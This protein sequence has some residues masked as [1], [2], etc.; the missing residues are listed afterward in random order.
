MYG[1]VVA[2]KT[3][4]D[5][6]IINKMDNLL[7]ELHGLDS[8]DLKDIARKF[9]ISLTPSGKTALIQR[10]YNRYCDIKKYISYT[11][12]KQLGHEGKDGRTF[13]ALDEHNHEVAIKI[14][15]K[16]KNSHSIEREAKLQSIAAE[17]GIAPKVL[18][19]DGE[20][21]FIVMEKLDVNLFDC[22][23]KQ[24]GQLTRSQQKW[25]IKLFKK[26]DECKVFHGDPNPLNF[27]KKGNKW[28]I[29][30]FGF[31][32]LMN[33][34]NRLRYGDTPNMTYMPLGLKMKLRKVYEHCELEIIERYC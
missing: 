5:K 1:S 12:V 7:I 17:K 23:K 28:F 27:M 26:L 3:L 16:H 6:G 18:H 20:G 32:K 25:I 21:K 22:F 33:R 34:T 9:N 19:Y 11:Y 30:D 2:E 14:F 13:L 15:R 10:I 4:K 24:N 29:I 31:S 8:D